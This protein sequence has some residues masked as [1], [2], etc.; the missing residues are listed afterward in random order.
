MVRLFVLASL[1]CSFPLAASA[2]DVCECY[3]Y[4][5]CPRD[6][7]VDEDFCLPNRSTL[8]LSAGVV[9]GLL[10]TDCRADLGGDGGVGA[11]DLGEVLAAWGAV[12]SPEGALADFDEDLEVGCFDLQ[13]LLGNWA[14]C[15]HPLDLNC[16]GEIE[17]EPYDPDDPL[18]YGDDLAVLCRNLGN[19][20]RGDLDRNGI[21]DDNDIEALS[22]LWGSESDRGDVNDDGEVGVE[23]L[24]AI[25][26]AYG[27]DCRGDFVGQEPGEDEPDGCVCYPDLLVLIKDPPPVH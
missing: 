11:M 22:C 18:A 14:T 7:V 27:R 1:L 17:N 10:P 16:N 24:T 26:A 2:D 6:P 12:T 13:F 19:D 3:D 5:Y 23:D 20:C 21:I 15:A 25:L 4:T 9:S 8:Q